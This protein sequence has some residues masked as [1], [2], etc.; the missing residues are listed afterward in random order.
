MKLVITIALSA[1]AMPGAVLAQA[2][3]PDYPTMA[4]MLHESSLSR[5]EYRDGVTSTYYLPGPRLRFLGF[6]PTQI[7]VADLYGPLTVS[8]SLPGNSIIP[9][10]AAYKAIY[11]NYSSHA[12]SGLMFQI[13]RKGNKLSEAILQS[14]SYQTSATLLCYYGSGKTK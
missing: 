6:Q 4:A 9:Y 10:E 13:P 2:C 14:M 3:P 8:I 7:Q 1:L 12:E 5:T 11:P